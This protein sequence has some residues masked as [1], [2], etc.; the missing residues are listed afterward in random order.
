MKV[1]KLL[2]L[3]LA[4]SSL[5]VYGQEYPF[6]LICSG[7]GSAGANSMLVN[8]NNPITGDGV[9]DGVSFVFTDIL[10]GGQNFYE[11]VGW[12]KSQDTGNTRDIKHKIEISIN[13]NSGQYIVKVSLMGGYGRSS[14]ANGVCEKKTI[15]RKF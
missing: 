6:E 9:I 2:S 3:S 12:P 4:F 1:N 15:E 14:S 8:F 7:S 13:R 11:L 10:S 5:A